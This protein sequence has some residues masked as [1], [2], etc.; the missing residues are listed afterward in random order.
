MDLSLLRRLALFAV[1]LALIFATGLAMSATPA[2][3]GAQPNVLLILLDNTGWGDFGAYGGGALRGAPTP[4]LDKLAGE[5]M[6]LLNFNTEAQCTP[7]RSALLTG[8]FAVRSGNQSVPLGTRRYGLVPWEV[9]MAEALRDRGYATALF[10]KWHLGHTLGRYP[11]D[12]GFDEWFGIA[13]SSGEAIYNDAEW[14]SRESILADAQSI[15]EAD[16]PKLLEGKP[17]EAPRELRRFDT[18][19]RR[20]ID[21]EITERTIAFMKRQ[22]KAGKPFFAYVPMTAM[23]FPSLPHP[24]FAGKSGHGNYADMLVQ[25]DAYIGVMLR[26]LD[27][28]G[29]ARDTVVIVTADNG[30]E[31]PGNGNGQY[32]GWTG[33]WDGTYFTALEGG[34]RTAFIMRWPGQVPAGAVNNEIV[35]LVDVFPTLAAFTGAAVPADRPI[36]GVNMAEFFLGKRAQSGREGFPIYVGDDLR[37]LK[38]RN[39]KVHFAWARTKYDPVAR[40][41]TVPKVVDLIRDPR[42]ERTV[43]EPANAWLQFTAL[44]VM[45][46]FLASTRQF[47]NVPVG[48]P[49]EFVPD[50]ASNK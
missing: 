41:S 14:L 10:G 8:R 35:H 39:W 48:A 28:L 25:T 45:G 49:D 2:V 7:S 31:D 22:K 16:K 20:R 27:E 5:G 6:R 9:T 13:N 43:P 19:E 23:H 21:G 36:D 24:D 40:Y 17:G 33:P 12:Q 50:Y 47:P 26:A 32:T 44:P 29:L 37:A 4:N 42:E 3:R 18:N 30:P 1:P 34:L 15:D 11:S 38:W 46:R